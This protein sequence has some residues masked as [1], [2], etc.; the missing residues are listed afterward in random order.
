MMQTSAGTLFKKENRAR[1]DDRLAELAH[2]YREKYSAV[3][4]PLDE[5]NQPLVT[6]WTSRTYQLSDDEID[7]VCT[8][9]EC[10]AL[11]IRNDSMIDVDLDRPE[12]VALAPAFL[13]EHTLITGRTSRPRSHYLF[14]PGDIL[15]R[16]TE[17]KGASSVWQGRTMICEL[18]AGREHYTILPEGVH[19]SGE[20]T[21]AEK[22]AT[23]KP[24]PPKKA[25]D[26]LA[27]RVA[28]LAACCVIAQYWQEGQR[29]R[30]AI[31][32]VRVLHE[33]GYSADEAAQIIHHMTDLCDDEE[34]QYRSSKAHAFYDDMA[35]GKERRI[36][37]LPTLKELCGDDGELVRELFSDGDQE[38]PEPVNLQEHDAVPEVPKDAVPT[39]LYNRA[40]DIAERTLTPIEA[41]LFPSMCEM[42]YTVG[43]AVRVALKTHSDDEDDAF[44]QPL[45]FFGY[46]AMPSGAGK[47]PAQR[48]ATQYLTKLHREAEE[49]YRDAMRIW[50]AARDDPELVAGERPERVIHKIK[51]ITIEALV[52]A[53]DTNPRGMMMSVDELSLLTAAAGKYSGGKSTDEQIW[54]EMYDAGEINKVRAGDGASFYRPSSC[55]QI[56][57]GIQPGILPKLLTADNKLLGLAARFNLCAIPELPPI[58]LVDKA[59]RPEYKERHRNR[60]KKLR[61]LF[62]P[63]DEQGVYMFRLDREAQRLFNDKEIELLHET[64]AADEPFRTHLGKYRGLLGRIALLWHLAKCDLSK[65]KERDTVMMKNIDAI[66][67]IDGETMQQAIIFLDYLAEHAKKIYRITDMQSGEVEGR[68]LARLLTDMMKADKQLPEYITAG[69]VL[70]RER[71]DLKST[72]AIAAGALWL[73]SRNWC[74]WLP[75]FKQPGKRGRPSDR[76]KINP[77][78]FIDSPDHGN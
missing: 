55:V 42:A 44:V 13:P 8:R 74:R 43:S 61:E 5:K 22:T 72:D 59:P 53:H 75:N 73:E 37:G 27:L 1:R 18:R 9:V 52:K 68:A 21:H 28:H 45:I 11:G 51:D 35:A 78:L 14:R 39:V 69:Q 48:Q 54:C 20:L 65:V 46:V 2:H 38:W 66:E 7:E 62:A 32:L 60:L 58:K 34:A 29:D 25:P 17:Y 36:P 70:H 63:F 50:L 12:A 49:E 47:S 56:Y 15:P 71:A 26:D 77:L 67:K 64:R 76:I 57:G 23:G 41:A 33:R 10:V 40:A 3:I 16:F 6:D 4:V 24:M 19:K 30:M 31:A